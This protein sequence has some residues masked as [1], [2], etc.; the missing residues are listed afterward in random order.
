MFKQFISSIPGA[1]VYMIFSL[2]PFL[3]FFLLVGVYLVL[4]DRG[5]RETME[6]LPLNDQIQNKNH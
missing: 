2:L 1:D 5:Y 4:M 3:L 6:N